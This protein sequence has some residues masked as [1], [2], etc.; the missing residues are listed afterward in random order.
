MSADLLKLY[1]KAAPYRYTHLIERS[2][3]PNMLKL[4]E[5]LDTMYGKGNYETIT[6][7]SDVKV[8][9]S[10]RAC[11]LEKL[12]EKGVVYQKLKVDGD[13]A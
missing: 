4:S 13:S 10:E 8:I 5:A 7:G 12:R 2:N 3:I 1:E 9:T 6:S 11:P